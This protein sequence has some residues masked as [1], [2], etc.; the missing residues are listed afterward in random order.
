MSTTKS[1][2]DKD[3]Y[4]ANPHIGQWNLTNL[5]INRVKNKVPRNPNLENP[6]YS[7]SEV[8][9]PRTV[10][11]WGQRKLFLTELDFILRYSDPDDTVIYIGAAPGHHLSFLAELLPDINFHLYDRNSFSPSLGNLIQSESRDGK[12]I[13]EVVLKHTYFEEDTIYDYVDDEKYE[14]KI[15]FLS[16]IRTADTTNDER[17]I[18]EMKIAKDMKLQME[19]YEALNPKSALL[20]FRLPYLHVKDNPVLRGATTFKYLDGEAVIQP[21]GRRKSTETRLIPKGPGQYKDWDLQKYSDAMYTHNYKD[22]V[23]YYENY[24]DIRGLDFCYDCSLEKQ[25]W[26]RYIKTF[27]ILGDVTEEIATLSN[28]LN[29]ILSGNRVFT[30]LNR[31]HFKGS[32]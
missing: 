4:R 27:N 13:R 9:F 23:S 26:N 25:I 8:E 5:K 16:D 21:F 19:I 7:F 3:I 15:L 20:K 30:P 17:H 1:L 12:Q 31:P 28:D 6:E 22:R 32:D 2:T 11:H 14:G 10:C 24:P 29:K 18:S